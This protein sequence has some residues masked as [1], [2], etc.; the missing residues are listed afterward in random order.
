LGF[1]RVKR[2]DYLG[3]RRAMLAASWLVVAFLGSY[4]LKVLLL[5]H[6][7]LAVWDA[8]YLRTLHVHETCVLV[9]LLCGAG[10]L[11]H[12][13]RLELPRGAGSAPIAPLKLARGLRLH[14]ILGRIGIGAS[15]LGFATAA[16]VLW[17]MYERSGAR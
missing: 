6:E 3:H 13:H 11:I 7:N 8:R 15:A 5:G 1:L 12:A 2:R 16:Y 17:G 4:V 14:R 9:M 10:A